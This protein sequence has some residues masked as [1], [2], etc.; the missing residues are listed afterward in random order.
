MSSS[1]QLTKTKNNDFI[2]ETD[3][4]MSQLTGFTES[5]IRILELLPAPVDMAVA[6]KY[7]QKLP[8]S[9]RSYFP[10]RVGKR[11]QQQSSNSMMRYND[12][13]LNIECGQGSMQYYRRDPDGTISV[14]NVRINKF[15]LS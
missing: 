7:F 4:R 14:I 10:E 12:N 1:R 13:G 9:K 2:R 11:V 6:E 3:R 5:E 15:Y 8:D